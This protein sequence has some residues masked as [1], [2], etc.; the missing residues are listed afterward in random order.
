MKTKEK[1]EKS[2]CFFETFFSLH[3]LEYKVRSKKR[4]FALILHIANIQVKYVLTTQIQ[5]FDENH[6]FVTES[7]ISKARLGLRLLI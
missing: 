6:W 4:G 5:L 3:D 2:N 1:G 7:L